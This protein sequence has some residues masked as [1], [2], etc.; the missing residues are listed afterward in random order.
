MFN[1]KEKELNAAGYTIAG[2]QVLDASGGPVAGEAAYGDVWYADEHVEAIMAGEVMPSL[3]TTTAGSASNQAMVTVAE[4]TT[5]VET[6]VVRA[7]NA[8]GQ[9]VG[10]DPSTPDINEAWTTKIKKKV[11]GKKKAKKD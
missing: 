11:I 4:E 1:N 5:I 9:L 8:K 6:E 7:R 10:D 2:G 3:T